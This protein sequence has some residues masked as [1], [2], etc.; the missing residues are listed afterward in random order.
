MEGWWGGG[1]R[2]WWSGGR[3]RGGGSGGGVRGEGVGGGGGWVPVGVR[4]KTTS[5]SVAKVAVF[6]RS[7]SS[8]YNFCYT[9]LL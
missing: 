2:G 5:E 1:W 4:E 3:R 7:S 8:D 9:A 6:V